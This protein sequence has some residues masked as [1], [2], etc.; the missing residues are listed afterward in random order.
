MKAVTVTAAFVALLATSSFAADFVE[1]RPLPR[2]YD[3]EVAVT[4]SDDEVT[5]DVMD[6]QPVVTDKR[7]K[8]S[9]KKKN[10]SFHVASNTHSRGTFWGY[11]VDS[12]RNPGEVRDEKRAVQKR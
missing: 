8:A 3:S 4:D 12:Y 1:K 6:A 7:I 10:R 5:D 9:N 2:P 11:K